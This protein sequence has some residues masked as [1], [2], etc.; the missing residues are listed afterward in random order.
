MGDATAP[1]S[2]IIY[3][4][5]YEAALAVKKFA[6]ADNVCYAG[7][8][9]LSRDST[10]INKAK[11]PKSRKI[12]CI[13]FVLVMALLLGTVCAC[14]FFALEVSSLKSEVASLRIASLSSQQSRYRFGD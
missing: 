10:G 2:D 6:M 13:L 9:P 4:E 11:S 3:D 8:T 14:I 7:I 12:L 1:S 5:V